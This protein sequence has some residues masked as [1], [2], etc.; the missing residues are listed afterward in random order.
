MKKTFII[1][2]CLTIFSTFI[3]A[4]SKNNDSE[5]T[6]PSAVREVT[7]E[8]YETEKTQ[9]LSIVPENQHTNDK[10]ASVRI[11]Y[12]PLYD[13][14]RI[15]YTTLYVTFEKG[16]AMNTVIAVMEDFMKEHKYFHYRY[17]KKDRERYFKDDRGQRMAEYS[18]YLKLSR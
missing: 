6:A 5:W 4:Q 7:E 18:S 3:F 14:V 17:L 13:E 16:E 15:Y 11:E 2:T 1:F 12:S 10:N 8:E 9:T